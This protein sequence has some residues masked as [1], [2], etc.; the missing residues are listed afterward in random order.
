MR[1]VTLHAPTRH[2]RGA[3]HAPVTFV[4]LSPTDPLLPRSSIWSLRTLHAFTALYTLK[5]YGSLESNI[6]Y[7]HVLD[8]ISLSHRF[9]LG[10]SQPGISPGA[11]LSLLPLLAPD[12]GHARLTSLALSPLPASASSVAFWS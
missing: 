7:E 6:I 4:P 3:C 2:P 8:R 1:L 10:S 5:S 9:A 11:W 12:P